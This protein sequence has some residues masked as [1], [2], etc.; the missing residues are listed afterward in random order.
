MLL[1]TFGNHTPHQLSFIH[2]QHHRWHGFNRVSDDFVCSCHIATTSSQPLLAGRPPTYVGPQ[3]LFHPKTA[4]PWCMFM[5]HDAFYH[6][7]S[8][9]RLLMTH[10]AS[11]L[12]LK[13]S[14]KQVSR[15]FRTTSRHILHHPTTHHSCCWRLATTHLTK[16][17][18]SI[19]S[20]TDDTVSIVPATILFAHVMLQR[21]HHSHCWL[22][23]HPATY[24]CLFFIRKQHHQHDACWWS[25]TL[26]TTDIHYLDC[27]WHTK[28]HTRNNNC[29]GNEFQ[30]RE[31]RTT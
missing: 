12:Q 26:F 7:Y 15:D 27:W 6:W 19:I 21:H 24:V 2:L 23:D 13:S 28:H 25:M 31:F 29:F 10:K 3:P 14:W 9:S 30:E 17:P 1:I 4:P 11:H 8:S 22:A 18:T 5:I 20:I 16:G